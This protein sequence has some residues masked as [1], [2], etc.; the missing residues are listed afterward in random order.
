MSLASLAALC[1]LL[2]LALGPLP[3]ADTKITAKLCGGGFVEIPIKRK[4][5]PDPPCSA[6]A[7]HAGSCRKRF[8]LAQ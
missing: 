8:D 1:A 2:P 5:P 3:A 7:C 6:K 4:S